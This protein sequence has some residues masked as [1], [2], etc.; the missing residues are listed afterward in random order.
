MNNLQIG[1][2]LVLVGEFGLKTGGYVVMG[3]G[4]LAIVITSVLEEYK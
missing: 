4:F 2:I 1:L 3:I